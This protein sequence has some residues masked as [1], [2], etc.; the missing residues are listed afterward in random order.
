[1]SHAH[2][3]APSERRGRLTPTRV[4]AAAVVIGSFS[5]WVVALGRIGVSDPLDT[6]EDRAFAEAAEPRCA[7]A[8]ADVERLPPASAARTATERAV[9]IDEATDRLEALVGELRALAPGSGEDGRVV[10]AWLDDW[11]T[12]LGDRRGYAARLRDDETAEL[13]LSTR[14]GQDIT[15]PMDNLANVN[16]MPSCATPGDVG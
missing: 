2:A 14:R 1:M 15:R 4:L 11:A 9:T 10:A 16:G 7:A 13:Q 12:Y 8:L 3:E 6:L 5:L